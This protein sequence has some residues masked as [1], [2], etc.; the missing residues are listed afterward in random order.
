MGCQCQGS[1]SA[2]LEIEKK[3]QGKLKVG[4]MYIIPIFAVIP[5]KELPH[6]I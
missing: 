2:R 4:L 3:V 5:I 1:R 6:F